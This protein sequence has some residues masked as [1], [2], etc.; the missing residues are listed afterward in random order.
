MTNTQPI[1]NPTLKVSNEIRSAQT[2]EVT[3]PTPLD[4]LLTHPV[5]IPHLNQLILQL[6]IQGKLVPQG[7]TDEP[8]AVLLERIAAEKARLVAEK[9]IRKSKPLPPITED[10]IPFDVPE[11][12]EWV[13]LDHICFLITDGTHHTPTYVNEGVP[14]LSVKDVS[15]GFINFSNTRFITR[16]EHEKLIK[17]CHPEFGDVLLT[18]VGTTGI[19]KVIDTTKE[20]SIF[21]SVSLLKFDQNEIYPIFLE[22]LLNAPLVKQQSDQFTMGVGNKNLVLKYIKNFVIPLPPLAEQKRI[23]AKVESLLGLCDSLQNQLFQGETEQSRLLA[24]LLAGVVA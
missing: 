6:A 11:G 4:L 15:K 3:S 18:K 24:S 2:F 5:D 21:V 7:P 23:V 9:K 12:W 13:R 1:S 10:E 19:A 16:E 8:A 14:F 22:Y 20:F 17:R